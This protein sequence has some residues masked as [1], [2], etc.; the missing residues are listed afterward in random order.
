[1]EILEVFNDGAAEDAFASIE[2]ISAFLSSTVDFSDPAASS[3]PSEDIGTPPAQVGKRPYQRPKKELEYLRAKHDTLTRQL[4]R[5]QERQ[6]SVDDAVLLP[7]KAR[8][9]EQAKS[10]QRAL[11]ENARLRELVEDQLSVIQALEKVLNKRPKLVQFPP[12]DVTWKQAILGTTNRLADLEQLMQHQLEKL[13]CEWIRHGLHDAQIERKSF[14]KGFVESREQNANGDTNMGICFVG[15]KMAPLDFCTMSEIV[16]WHKTNPTGPNSAVLE[17]FHPDLVYV[18]EDIVLPDPTMPVMEA[19]TAL[20]KYVLE[21]RV[22]IVWRSIVQDALQPHNSNN[23]IC[24]RE[25]WTVFHA[26]D[27]TES[28]LQ[29]CMR[30]ATPIFPPALQAVQPA[31]GTLTELLLQATEENHIRFGGKL[32]SAIAAQKRLIDSDQKG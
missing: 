24:N 11:H 6:C 22:I 26:K 2:T 5:L 1:M 21:D 15:S 4:K 16:W 31:V 8:A 29:L 28:Y 17:A 23:L 32:H 10:A 18:R 13:E 30:M 9:V 12:P 14:H 3:S 19:R 7:W 20:R 27:A 25:G